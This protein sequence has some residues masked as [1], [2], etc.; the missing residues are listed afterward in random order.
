MVLRLYIPPFTLSVKRESR[1]FLMLAD[2]LC[3]VIAR[4]I[5]GAFI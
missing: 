5:F 2:H 4:W 1:A 3:F